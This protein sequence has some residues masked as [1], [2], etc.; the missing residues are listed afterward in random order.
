MAKTYF[1]SKS[2]KKTIKFCENVLEKNPNFNEIINIKLKSLIKIRKFKD[3]FEYLNENKS[4]ILNYEEIKLFLLEKEKN[5]NGNFNLF[6]ML[7]TEKTNFYQ[8]LIKKQ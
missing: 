3:A 8:N 1:L 5:Q 7:K 4:K 6:E 2:Y